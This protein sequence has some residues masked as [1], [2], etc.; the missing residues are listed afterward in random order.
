MNTTE[1]AERTYPFTPDEL[2]DLI[3]KI[4]T[5]FPDTVI[6]ALPNKCEIREDTFFTHEE[7]K[8]YKPSGYFESMNEGEYES[9]QEQAWRINRELGVHMSLRS[10]EDRSFRVFDGDDILKSL[11]SQS[12][13][14]TLSRVNALIL[15]YA[16]RQ[17]E[18][19]SSIGEMGK[20]AQKPWREIIS[21]SIGWQS[22]NNCVGFDIYLD[23]CGAPKTESRSDEPQNTISN[24]VYTRLCYKGTQY[25]LTK[26]Q[27]QIITMLNKHSTPEQGL[28]PIQIRA[29][30]NDT[31]KE[32][33]F[34][35]EFK[36]AYYFKSK[37][38]SLCKTL[39][40]RSESTPYK[41][42]LAD[43]LAHEQ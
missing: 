26:R 12:D 43:V 24:S 36:I 5:L 9:N 4:P 2:S 6:V 25:D 29:L 18:K 35:G 37:N 10:L 33:A 21:K 39:I 38:N 40:V 17:H 11:V 30:I 15:E 14:E 28:R 16:G 42:S 41:Y 32:D 3:D 13:N 19:Y 27:W 23:L 34:Q 1:Q 20:D 8:N 7:M 31:Y 22:T